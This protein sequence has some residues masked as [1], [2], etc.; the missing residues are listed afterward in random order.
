[1]LVAIHAAA[2]WL[3]AGL[4]WT[5]QLVHYPSLENAAPEKFARN[6]RRTVPFVVPVMLVEAVSAIL[7]LRSPAH[8]THVLE[9]V[10]MA[11]LVAIWASTIVFQYP[12]HLRLARSYSD[13]DFAKLMRTN[14]LR[15][16]AWSARGAVAYELLRRAP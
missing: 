9:Y 6:I 4:I 8:Q 5:M 12:L 2:T 16:A 10:G 3:M 7:L 11:L 15:V 1:M 13:D 14:W